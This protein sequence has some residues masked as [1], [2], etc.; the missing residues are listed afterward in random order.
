MSAFFTRYEGKLGGHFDILWRS[1]DAQLMSTRLMSTRLMSAFFTRYKGQL[2]GH[3]DILWRSFDAKKC[4][5]DIF[6]EGGGGLTIL[7]FWTFI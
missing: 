6:L 2:R 4:P 5:L 3:F 7:H 1:F